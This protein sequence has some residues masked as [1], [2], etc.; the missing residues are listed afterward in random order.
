LYSNG[1][2]GKYIK[3]GKVVKIGDP[4]NGSFQVACVSWGRLKLRMMKERKNFLFPVSM[5]LKYCLL[6]F[7]LLPISGL[8]VAAVC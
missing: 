7:Y 5:L 4:E 6:P 8:V 2:R 3:R 1:T